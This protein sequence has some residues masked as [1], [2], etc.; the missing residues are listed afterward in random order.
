MEKYNT[1]F[2]RFGAGIIDGMV[3]VPFSI[4][5]SDVSNNKALFI[6]VMFLYLL[7]WLIYTAGMHARFGQTLGKMATGIKVYNINEEST[8]TLT[9]AIARES[10]WCAAQLIALINFIFV[11]LERNAGEVILE[12]YN[13]SA[14]FITICWIL[15][16]LITM[17]TNLKR[18][19]LQDF[20]ANSVVIKIR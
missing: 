14:A 17:L 2:K 15:I 9:A 19:S 8:I 3:F 4:L 10:F 18:R 5:A 7:F 12:K 16:E 20:I 13:D 6:I 11:T 1:F